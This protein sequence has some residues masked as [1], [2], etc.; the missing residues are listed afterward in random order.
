MGGR[1]P[2]KEV[3]FIPVPSLAPDTTPEPPAAAPPAQN[4]APPERPDQEG[5]ERR[6]SDH[7]QRPDCARVSH[8]V[9]PG[10]TQGRGWRVWKT[11][12]A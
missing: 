2:V 1:A 7:S 10:F 9:P 8:P 11:T 4:P 5:S 12:L 6:R 3:V